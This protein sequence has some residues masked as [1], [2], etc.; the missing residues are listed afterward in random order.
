MD[1]GSAISDTGVQPGEADTSEEDEEEREKI[2]VE[3]RFSVRPKGLEDLFLTSG[4]I[5][6]GN[7]TKGEELMRAFKSC[8]NVTRP[9]DVINGTGEEGM[10]LSGGLRDVMR[11]PFRRILKRVLYSTMVAQA[12]LWW[13]LHRTRSVEGRR[14]RH[15]FESRW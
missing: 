12:I 10:P 11:A 1:R 4:R 9:E 5:V 13:S 2:V 6:R 15:L 8:W 14:K 3:R 7:F